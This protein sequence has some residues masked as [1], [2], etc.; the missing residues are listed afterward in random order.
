MA[1][2]RM[3]TLTPKAKGDY[4]G[5]QKLIIDAMTAAKRP[6]STPQIAE[7]IAGSLQTR[8]DPQRVVA[9]YM[10]VWKKKG[11]VAVSEVDAEVP[12]GSAAEGEGEDAENGDE[13]EAEDAEGDDAEA[14]E[15][16]GDGRTTETI[17]AAD[18]QTVTA[19]ELVGEVT[20]V[21]LHGASV[22]EAL[23]FVIKKEGAC[24][25]IKVIEQLDSMAYVSP[26]TGRPVGV[27]NIRGAAQNLVRRGELRKIGN[28]Q[29]ERRS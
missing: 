4:K 5:Q 22:S 25:A 14:E 3:F 26:G 19:E 2:V 27:E 20:P 9:F 8:Q 28:D 15:E 29:W 7:E 16:T 21:T 11:M 17:S 12:A 6:L 24:T 18:I 1:I 10:S 23:L 13:D